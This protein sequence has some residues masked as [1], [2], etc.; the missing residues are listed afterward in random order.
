MQPNQALIFM[1]VSKNYKYVVQDDIQQRYCS[2]TVATLHPVVIYV[3]RDGEIKNF[4]LCIF[5]EDTKHDILMVKAITQ[6]IS[7][8]VK[9]NFPK[10]RHCEFFT[11]ECDG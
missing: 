1:D 6:K 11:D 10:V 8:H 4:N 9:E 2:Q 7:N 5:S 3:E